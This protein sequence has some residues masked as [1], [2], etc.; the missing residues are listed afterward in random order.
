MTTTD[1][2]QKIDRLLTDAERRRDELRAQIRRAEPGYLGTAIERELENYLGQCAALHAVRRILDGT[3]HADFLH[4]WEQ[5]HPH[6]H[7]PPQQHEPG[8]Q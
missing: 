7:E 5:E 8:D 4:T 2:R 3:E 6:D 1:Q